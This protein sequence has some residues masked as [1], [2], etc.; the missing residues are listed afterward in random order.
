VNRRRFI[1]IVSSSAV[2]AYAF[3][4]DKLLWVPG[5]KTIFVPPPRQ[6]IFA[7][8][9]TALEWERTMDIVKEIYEKDNL[10]YQVLADSPKYKHETG[11]YKTI[12]IYHGYKIGVVN[13]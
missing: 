11:D 8:E 1:Q 4:L 2:S 5:Q 7:S 10:L 12:Q 3:D 6:L 9:V 13:E